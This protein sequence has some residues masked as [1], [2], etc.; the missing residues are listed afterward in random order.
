MRKYRIHFCDAIKIA[1]CISRYGGIVSYSK[2]AV[3]SSLLS[4]YTIYAGGGWTI[5]SAS[6]SHGTVHVLAMTT[7]TRNHPG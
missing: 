5:A 7:E 2:K 4:V 6:F 3:R 1:A